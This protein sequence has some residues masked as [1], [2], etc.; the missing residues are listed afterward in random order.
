MADNPFGA[1]AVPANENFLYDWQE[2]AIMAQLR[3]SMT[4][5]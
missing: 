2:A 4:S 3:H 5:W 1:I